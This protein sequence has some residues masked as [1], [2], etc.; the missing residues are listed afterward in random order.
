M[1]ETSIYNT[2][3]RLYQRLTTPHR[4]VLLFYYDFIVIHRQ[5]ILEWNI[6]FLT[7]G[8]LLFV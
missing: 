2:L 1:Q 7:I 8:L 6:M 5:R 3:K 4:L